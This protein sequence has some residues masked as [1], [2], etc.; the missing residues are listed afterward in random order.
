MVTKNIKL[1]VLLMFLFVNLPIDFINSHNEFNKMNL[2]ILSPFV[3]D[4]D[5]ED[6]DW[7][8]IAVWGPEQAGTIPI[9]FRLW[10]NEWLPSTLD[11]ETCKT[12]VQDDLSIWHNASG[13]FSFPET[14]VEENG[15]KLWFPTATAAFP[16]PIN[17]GAVTYMALEYDFEIGDKYVVSTSAPINQGI[18]HTEM[19]FNNTYSFRFEFVNYTE[20]LDFDQVCFKLVVLH[21]IGHLIG[22]AD[23]GISGAIMYSPIE[24]GTDFFTLG[25][26]DFE[27]LDILNVVTDIC[28]TCPPETPKNFEAT[29]VGQDVVLTWDAYDYYVIGF[30]VYRN[31]Q[32]IALTN[33]QTSYTYANAV[34]SLPAE[35]KLGGYNIYGESITEPINIIVSPSSINSYV[36][37]TGVIFI[38]SDVTISST[39]SLTIGANTKVIFNSGHNY[40]LVVNGYLN[41]AGTI[42]NPVLFS[43]NG[44]APSVGSWESIS[45]NGSEASGSVLKYTNIKF[46]TRVEVINTS[47]ITI[48]YCTIDTTYDG[49]YFYNSTGS[50]LNNTITTNS[51]GAGIRIEGGSGVTCNDNVVTKTSANQYGTGILYGGGSGGYIA[52]NDIDH[53]YWGIGAIWGA[54]PISYSASVQC[55]NRIRN[56]YIGLDVYRNSD[57]LFGAIYSSHYGNNSLSNNSY[58]AVVG[59]SYPTYSSEL[60]AHCNW[61]GD[62][63]PDTQLFS[64]GPNADFSYNYPLQTDPCSGMGKMVAGNYGRSLGGDD[65]SK[66]SVNDFEPLIPGIELRREKQYSEA[67]DF[68]ISFINNH[69]ENQAAYVELYNCYS[70]E[71]A[72]DLINYFSSL[73]KEASKDHKLL[74]SYLYLKNG[75]VKEARK[76]NNAIISENP[77]TELGTRA[78]LNNVYVSLYNERNVNEA[79]A[80]FNEVMNKA[81]LSTPLELNLVYQDIEIYRKTYG[82]E[83]KGLT[84]PPKLNYFEEELSKPDVLVKKG[85]PDKYELVGNYPNPFNPT[86][87]ISYALPYQSSVEVIIYDIIGRVIKSFDI[88]SQSAGYQSIV[89]DGKNEIGNSV[90]SGI[91][92]YRISIKSLENSKIFVKTAKLM[93]LK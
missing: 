59:V 36:F 70:K 57:F 86:T 12:Q 20:D 3:F 15:V 24:A 46:G 31:G 14:Q 2:G 54:S 40:S 61:W 80:I 84:V 17:D 37:W 72:N 73:P 26:P 75:N 47:N 43:S 58:N 89:W 22:L 21:E 76:V 1:S 74:L 29:I 45:I 6:N 34:N 93:M 39:A 63:P 85:T 51:A 77:N 9:Y 88:S 16:D 62:Y 41:S 56:C 25:Q 71:T 42:L 33:N 44:T 81:E 79:V 5:D 87:T 50:I 52:R 66:S 83:I 8:D 69:P 49:I 18:T 35:F 53:W 68:F 91:Y 64:V 48:R 30:K 38:N 27:G 92:L 67:K 13:S 23:C 32:Y 19:V 65:V 90:A 7:D 78:K 11:A 10:S 28:E 4:P 60:L 82:V 55:N